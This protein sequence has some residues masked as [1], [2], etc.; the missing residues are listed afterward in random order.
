MISL[1]PAGRVA[2]NTGALFAGRV[3]VMA[4]SFL[5]LLF[6]T[7]LLG[8]EGFGRYALIR[9]Y[10]DV[11]L[12][13]SATGLGTLLTREIAKSPSSTPV[14]F[15]TAVPLMVGVALSISGLLYVLSPTI[16]YGPDVRTLLW[17]ACV[18]LIP[19]SIGV[20][21]EAVFVANGNA[22][23]VMW[24]SFI[25]ALFYTSAGLVL[26]WLG[27]GAASLFVM[28][29][30]TRSCLAAAY[31]V[32]L[33]RQFGHIWRP[34]HWVFVK[35][36]CR[37][38]R[39]FA[40]ENWLVSL[41]IGIDTIV[42]SMFHREAVVGIYA[43]ASKIT[44]FGSPLAQSFTSAMFPYLSRLYGESTQAFRRISEESL[45][46][47]LAV[48]LPAA[49]LV[50]TFADA[51]I[52]GLYGEAYADA[53]PVLR[54]VIWMFVFRF[55]NPFVSHLLFARGEPAKSFRVAATTFVLLVCLSLLLTPSWGAVGAASA[56]LAS[57]TV[58][59]GLYCA[60]AFRPGL[61]RVLITFGRTG[62]AAASLAAFLAIGRQA[63]PV[64]LSIGAFGV[65]FGVLGLLRV[66]STHEL[67]A[68][69]R[70][71]YSG[72]PQCVEGRGLR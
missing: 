56:V 37:D 6:A 68:I 20:L 38:W 48:A 51:V 23:Y 44:N 49:V 14:Y 19:A 36:F 7:R 52:L 29:V 63:H 39:I 18:A 45:K 16:G 67:S 43:A 11:L 35:R 15:G 17:L 60:A 69:F 64:A 65:Y 22:H 26:L 46:Y 9:A 2:N 31:S 1:Q 3:L 41:T 72:R 32:V 10:F 5:F 34:G 40:F 27:Y 12:S 28:L 59:C 25:E 53:V 13:I 24:G 8:V 70:L 4:S 55:V 62:V 61:T 21:S 58:A 57:A 54:I 42:L 66:S 33:W 50:A 30:V 47:M 71:P